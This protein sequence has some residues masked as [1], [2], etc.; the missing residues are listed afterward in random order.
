MYD[1]RCESD[2]YSTNSSSSGEDDDADD[3]DLSSSETEQVCSFERLEAMAFSIGEDLETTHHARS[4]NV[5]Q[6]G[7]EKKRRTFR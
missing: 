1:D 7:R 4:A 5:D 3:D 2:S 6:E